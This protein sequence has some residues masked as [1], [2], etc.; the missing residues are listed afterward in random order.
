MTYGAIGKA[1]QYAG[2]RAKPRLKVG[3][4][5]NAQKKG[6]VSLAVPR[7]DQGAT[8]PANRAGLVTE[9][10]G[11]TDPETGSVINPNGVKGARR[12]DMLETYH[13]RG[14]ISDRGYTA[15]EALRDAWAEN[16]KG[17]GNDWSMERV[18][19]T[20]KPDAHIAIQ[21]ERVAKLVSVSRLVTADDMGILFAVA[22]DGHAISRL[23]RYRGAN[24]ERGKAHLREALERLAD[25]LKA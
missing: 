1:V 5:V 18:D 25:A 11:V 13:R 2:T 22:C 24:H 10:R 23:K 3:T 16:Q 4:N 14:W 20:P 21:I 17:Q 8:G 6:S 7:W 19:S 15:G 12:V 9:G